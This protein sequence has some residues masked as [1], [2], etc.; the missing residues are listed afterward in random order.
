LSVRQNGYHT[1]GPL[2]LELQQYID[3]VLIYM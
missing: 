2:V 1:V 3:G